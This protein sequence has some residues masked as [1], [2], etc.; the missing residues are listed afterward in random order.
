LQSGDWKEIALASV[1]KVTSM[2]EEAWAQVK[3]VLITSSS[4]A[5]KVDSPPPPVIAEDQPVVV[6]PSFKENVDLPHNSQN[7]DSTSKAS[8]IKT[9]EPV[10]VQ[11]T[12][13][14]VGN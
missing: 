6:E 12:A 14:T 8:T 1:Q 11:E 2:A 4:T 9:D 5:D 13:Y 10:V 3:A 7:S